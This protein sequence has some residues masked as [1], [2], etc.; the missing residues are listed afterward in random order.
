MKLSKLCISF[1]IPFFI[2]IILLSTTADDAGCV[3]AIFETLLA[4]NSND[5]LTMF[6]STGKWLNDL[7]QID[8]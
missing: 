8:M 1:H 2:F 4:G 3:G 5:Q 7:G 6:L